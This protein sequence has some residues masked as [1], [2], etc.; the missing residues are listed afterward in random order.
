MSSRAI[1]LAATES[2][3][4]APGYKIGLPLMAIDGSIIICDV[5]V[6]GL[7]TA[8]VPAGTFQCFRLKPFAGQ[9]YWYCT[10]P[11]HYLV[12]FGGGPVV[13]ELSAVRD[14]EK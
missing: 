11:H 3:P 1:F 8:P 2:L 13:A 10:D 7:E 5:E 9:T 6:S 14:G 12:K 4:L